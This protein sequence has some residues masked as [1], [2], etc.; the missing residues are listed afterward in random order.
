MTVRIA[1]V[2]DIHANLPALDAVLAAIDDDGG[3]DATYHLGDLVGYAPWPNEVV[4]RITERGIAGIAG[5]YDSTVSTDYAHCGCKYEDP[6]QEAQSHES[7]AWTRVAVSPATKRALGA[8]PF[9]LDLRPL[10]G[11]ASAP[12]VMLVHGTPTLNTLYW[13][14]DRTPE[15]DRKMISAA[16]ARAGDVIAFGHTHKP[17][18]REIDGVR[19][20]NTGSVGRPKDG[21]PRAVYVA[22][23]VGEGDTRVTFHRVAYDVEAAAAGILAST[24]P[25][26][27][28]DFLR[29]GGA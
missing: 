14:E 22:L 2:S 12:T 6:V 18:T 11:H 4:A 17:W 24:L 19:L 26:A 29:R 9:R 10:G 23:D 16:G 1:L 7:Y 3:F 25:H 20:V 27:F 8:L 21:D 13:T 15:F 5:N 28:A